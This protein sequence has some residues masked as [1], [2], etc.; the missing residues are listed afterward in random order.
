MRQL[1][2]VSMVCAATLVAG[3]PGGD[4]TDCVVVDVE[5]TPQYEPT[6]A[7][8]HTNTFAPTCALEG[9][10][11]HAAAGARGGLILE[12]ED[13]AYRFLVEDARA[14][15]I[16]GD[17]A[18]SELVGRVTGLGPRQKMPPGGMLAD[19]EICAIVQWIADGAPR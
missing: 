6:L 14:R 15:V 2:L 9:T 1:H 17:P 11:C 4:D 12:S 13:D 19:G 7:N 10:A 8:I 3:C 18:C 5:C 16:P